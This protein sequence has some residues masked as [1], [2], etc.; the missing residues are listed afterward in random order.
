MGSEPIFQSVAEQLTAAEIAFN[1]PF[2]VGELPEA[3]LSDREVFKREHALAEDLRS[4]KE[5]GESALP[6]R[7]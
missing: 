6:A 7:S 4:A 1:T 5:A 2:K 3:G